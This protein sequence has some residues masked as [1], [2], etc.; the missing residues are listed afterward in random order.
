M[1]QMRLTLICLVFVFYM[2]LEEF[3]EANI[4]GKIYGRVPKTFD[5]GSYVEK[6][7]KSYGLVETVNRAKYF[8]SRTI[9]IFKH[10]MLYVSNKVSHYLKQN[11]FID[12]TPKE[13]KETFKTKDAGL[14]PVKEATKWPDMPANK[15]WSV[16]KFHQKDGEEFYSKSSASDLSGS[17]AM[18]EGLR[19]PVISFFGEPSIDSGFVNDL[20]SQPGV[21]RKVAGLNKRKSNLDQDAP[22][23]PKRK[24]VKYS[25]IV[26]PNNKNYDP[27]SLPSFGI[28]DSVETFSENF[29]K[30]MME[31]YF[32]LEPYPSAYESQK[33]TVN[34][35][36]TREPK[37]SVLSAL[38]NSISEFFDVDTEFDEN[39][40]DARS[41]LNEDNKTGA[42]VTKYEIDWRRTGCITRVKSQSRCNSCYAFASLDLM[43]FFYCRQKKVYTEFSA[44]YIIDCGD[45]TDLHGCE[46]GKLSNV[47]QFIQKYGIHSN[48]L[49]PYKGVKQQCPFSNKEDSKRQSYPLQ[50]IITAWRVFSDMVAWHQWLPR[51]PIIVGINM[52]SDFMAYGGG[53]HDGL[54][55]V[56]DM[57][58]AMLLVGSG[59][60]G[61]KPFWLLKNTFSDAWGEDGYFKLSQA[62][63]LRCFNSA[64]IARANFTVEV[65]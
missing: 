37:N 27:S 6:Y 23:E 34:N 5:Y 61:N 63:P 35:K 7:R 8:F 65:S 10:N 48:A 30:I 9:G 19:Q 43:E 58:H 18:P 50:P 38:L 24:R 53:I 60:H 39:S 28:Q 2:S 62:A 16:I 29:A 41:T 3:G 1:G 51:R 56:P 40:D 12:M 44:Q 26:E 49:Y 21:V 55:C 20:K 64:V 59:T 14:A 15:L 54:D 33:I 45:K 25:P 4:I 52:P 13:L 31:D 42:D 46:G 47:G 17:N 57:V 22:A 36:K 11:E 32:S